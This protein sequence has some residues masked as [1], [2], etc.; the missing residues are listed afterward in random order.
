MG[1][2]F[3]KEDHQQISPHN[4]SGKK[5]DRTNK[6]SAIANFQIILKNDPAD[7]EEKKVESIQEHDLS[8]DD[9]KTVYA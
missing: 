8:E 2:S 7:H 1:P 6:P 4:R 5:T 9:E 3:A